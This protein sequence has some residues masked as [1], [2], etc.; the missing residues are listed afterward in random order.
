MQ[1]AT[2][3]FPKP[4]F[5]H[6]KKVLLTGHTGFIGGWLW[7]WLQQ[8]Q[9][10]ML[11]YALPPVS[12]QNFYTLLN[13]NQ[14]GQER[15]ADIRDFNPLR[16]A[17]LDF[18]PDIILHLAA[19][20]L[21]RPAHADPLHTFTTNFNG[22]MQIL[23]I[24]REIP[25]LQG[26]VIFTTDKVYENIETPRGYREDDRL[27]GFEPYGAS[28][29]CAE[30]VTQAYWHSYFKPKGMPIA[31]LRAGNVIGG[32]DWSADR[33]IPDAVRAFA[34]SQPVIL[35][36]PE[37]VRP[38]QHVLEPCQAIL[39]LS[40]YIIQQQSPFFGLNIGPDAID[41]K[42]VGWVMDEFTRA[43]QDKTG[44]TASWR[45]EP[46]NRIYEAKLLLLD[47]ALARHNLG[48]QPRWSSQQAI[49]RTAEWYAAWHANQDLNALTR[50]QWQDF[51]QG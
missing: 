31:T 18:K 25:N 4:E 27:G 5:W 50:T 37:A 40:E 47:N 1:T 32:G 35:R 46:D 41:A 11:G 42:T 3:K 48:W 36:H 44:Q 26:V 12:E 6:G 15:L 21:V 38:W 51:I 34:Q 22:T 30:I 43:W 13:L 45:H 33:L 8:W 7:Y 49:A 10:E 19:Q 16:Q 20:A 2:A 28:K 17:V 23:E 14:H 39:Q 24:A 29:A 9:S